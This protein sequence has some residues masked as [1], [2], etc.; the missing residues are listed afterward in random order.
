MILTDDQRAVRDMARE[1]TKNELAPHAG[2]W[3]EAIAQHQSF[4]NMLAD[5]HTRLNAPR[6]LTLRAAGRRTQGVACLSDASQAK[7]YASEMA[8]FVCSKAI[9]I[10]GGDGFL[11]DYPV[12]RHYRDAR[13]TQIYE[14]TSE[15][16]RMLIAR[17]L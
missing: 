8:E 17:S 5:I 3:D 9:Q 7:L 4:A 13:V 14:G 6:L 1:F 15:V 16:Q 2:A 12:E 11:E 10:H